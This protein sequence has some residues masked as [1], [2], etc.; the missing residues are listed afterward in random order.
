MSQFGDR[1]CSEGGTVFQRSAL[2]RAGFLLHGA[3]RKAVD[4]FNTAVAAAGARPDAVLA[5]EWD[6]GLVV[7]EALRQPPVATRRPSEIRRYLE[8]N[9]M[10]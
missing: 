1:P 4:T 9:S 8:A 6:V 7:I 2:P 5:T 10:G 3:A